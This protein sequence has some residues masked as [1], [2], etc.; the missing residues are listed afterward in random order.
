MKVVIDLAAVKR[1]TSKDL[2]EEANCPNG[3]EEPIQG[4]MEDYDQS[5]VESETRF[6]PRKNGKGTIP[7]RM[8]TRSWGCL[9]FPTG[10]GVGVS[11]VSKLNRR[12][13]PPS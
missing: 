7:P 5:S 12:Q 1:V 8:N 4:W 11:D 10:D 2:A 3:K 9:A 13:V 6:A